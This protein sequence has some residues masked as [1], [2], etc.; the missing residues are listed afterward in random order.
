MSETESEATAGRPVVRRRRGRSAECQTR[1]KQ[2]QT[3][4]TFTIDK[5]HLKATNMSEAVSPAA[6]KQCFDMMGLAASL[7]LSRRI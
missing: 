3:S 7:S 2:A 1:R 5:H 6:L 4:V